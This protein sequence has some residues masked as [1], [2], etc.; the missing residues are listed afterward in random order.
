MS[1]ASCIGVCIWPQL[2]RKASHSRTVVIV[3]KTGINLARFQRILTKTS[4]QW[5]PLS[6]SCRNLT[7]YKIHGMW[8]IPH[9][10]TCHLEIVYCMWWLW[11]LKALPRDTVLVWQRRQTATCSV[12]I[13]KAATVYN[14]QASWTL[15]CRQMEDCQVLF[16]ELRGE[17]PI[18]W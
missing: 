3:A 16:R 8:Q 15:K 9:G 2:K 10:G 17:M 18:T 13:L 6:A 5:T 11:P 14:G 7:C 12:L 4:L 1:Q